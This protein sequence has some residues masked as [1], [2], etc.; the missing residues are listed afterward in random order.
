ML[1]TK[2]HCSFCSR[3]EA[4]SSDKSK[5][6]QTGSIRLCFVYLKVTAFYLRGAKKLAKNATSFKAAM[7]KTQQSGNTPTSCA[8]Q[9]KQIW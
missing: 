5:Q 3:Q 9:K 4:A 8:T 1:M 6:A 2:A 7:S